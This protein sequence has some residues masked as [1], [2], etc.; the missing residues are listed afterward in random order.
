MIIGVLSSEANAPVGQD[1][2]TLLL[3][4]GAIQMARRRFVVSARQ[5]TLDPIPAPDPRYGA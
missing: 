5:R 4:V 1:A 2:P 3:P